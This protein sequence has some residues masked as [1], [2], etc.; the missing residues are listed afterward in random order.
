M[1]ENWDTGYQMRNKIKGKK[2]DSRKPMWH[3][4]PFK[5][6]EEVV[7]ILTFG[8]NK[9]GED[10]WRFFV[11]KKDNDKRYVSAC[12]RHVSAFMNGDKNDE[13]TNFHHL[14]HAVCCLLFVM[15]KDQTRKR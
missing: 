14:A 11:S 12:L 7:K 3:L 15:W 5:Q 4:L 10:D 1:K 9:Y 2:F 6:L 13:E 8:A